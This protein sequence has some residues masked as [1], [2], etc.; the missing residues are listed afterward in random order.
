VGKPRGEAT[1]SQGAAP[2]SNGHAGTA[3]HGRPGRDGKAGTARRR[4]WPALRPYRPARDLYVP[5]SSPVCAGGCTETNVQYVD[6]VR[7]LA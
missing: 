6:P 7:I 3:R 4:S 1:W 2:I 5:E